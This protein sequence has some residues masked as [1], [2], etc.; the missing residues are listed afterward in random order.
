MEVEMLDSTFRVSSNWIKFNKNRR[1]ATPV[2][3]L[4]IADAKVSKT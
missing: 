2:F 4:K 1:T 3:A